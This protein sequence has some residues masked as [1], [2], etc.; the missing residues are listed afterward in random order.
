MNPCFASI[1]FQP[2]GSEPDEEDAAHLKT[3]LGDEYQQK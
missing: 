1:F 2:N 3:V